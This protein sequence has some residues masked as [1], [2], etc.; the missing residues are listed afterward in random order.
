MLYLL[1]C[2]HMFQVSITL[3]C[4][5]AEP[6]TGSDA[7]KAASQRFLEFQ[8]GWF[9]D[10]VFFGQYPP[11]MLDRVGDRYISC[12]QYKCSISFNAQVHPSLRA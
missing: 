10:P 6:L 5:W 7:D 11:A 4:D 1:H 12:Y 2:F 8:L 3:N 9:A